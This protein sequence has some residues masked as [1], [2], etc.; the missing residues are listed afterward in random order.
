[1][2]D[3]LNA[4]QQKMDEIKQRLDNITVEGE[5][6]E[7]GVK[8]LVTAN[9]KI[10]EVNISDQLIKTGDK[11]EI[12]ELTVVALNRALEQAENVSESEMKAASAGLFPDLPGML[13]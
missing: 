2:F 13:G 8:V 7:G 10:K 3:K 1:M 5:A 12:G 11:E 9:K 4:I 6:G